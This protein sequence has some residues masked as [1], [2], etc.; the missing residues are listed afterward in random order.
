MFIT[1][2]TVLH[3]Y[4]E[5]MAGGTINKRLDSSGPFTEKET[6]RCMRQILEGLAYLHGLNILHRDVKG[7][8][9]FWNVV[10]LSSVEKIFLLIVSVFQY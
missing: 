3:I 5:Y 6:K 2:K 4:M 1:E 9:C 8:Y 7:E 10:I